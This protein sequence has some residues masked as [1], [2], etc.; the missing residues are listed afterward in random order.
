[1][2]R[3]NLIPYREARR[4][5]RLN[6]IL[7]AWGATA[8]LGAGI[9]FA[10]DTMLTNQIA[11]LEENKRTKEQRI[12]QLDKQLG[13]IRDINEK[14]KLV[15]TR[16]Q[17][18]DNLKKDRFLPVRVMDELSNAIPEKIWLSNMTVGKDHISLTGVAQSNSEVAEFMDKLEASP[19]FG[20]INLG[21]LS[22]VS[23]GTQ[24]VRNF[25]LDFAVTSPNASGEPPKTERPKVKR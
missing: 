19:F 9:A 3:I 15:L 14:K 8:L 20:Q 18:I 10:V 11:E 16:L 22:T 21:P 23:M 12:V 4:K 5:Q 25:T 24:K 6:Q 7:A 1:M 13:E 17:T 2:I